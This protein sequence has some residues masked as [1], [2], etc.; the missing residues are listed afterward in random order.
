MLSVYECYFR[1][2]ISYDTSGPY[3]ATLGVSLLSD[4]FCL[5][6]CFKSSLSRSFQVSSVE[7][8]LAL[9]GPNMMSRRLTK[10]E[11]RQLGMP[12]ICEHGMTLPQI[13]FIVSQKAAALGVT[14]Y[15][16][17]SLLIAPDV[18]M[19]CSKRVG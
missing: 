8:L 5:I 15:Q 14:A 17:S 2:S 9:N 3:P 11:A 16:V 12:G 6:F 4:R 19:F 10:A 7:K 18:V 13:F 1:L